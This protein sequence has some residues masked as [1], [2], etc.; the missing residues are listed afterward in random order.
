MSKNYRWVLD[1]L[2]NSDS[3]HYLWS[4]STRAAAREMQRQHKADTRFSILGNLRKMSTRLLDQYELHG[5]A[6]VFVV[7]NV[8]AFY[9]YHETAGWRVKR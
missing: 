8:E 2:S 3:K 5:P 1:D 4:F 6:N 7:R 9:H